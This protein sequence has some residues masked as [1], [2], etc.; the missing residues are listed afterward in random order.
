MHVAHLTD[1]LVEPRGNTLPRG[2]WKYK[3][4]ADCAALCPGFDWTYSDDNGQLLN[5]TEVMKAAASSRCSHYR[6]IEAEERNTDKTTRSFQETLRS[7]S[8]RVDNWPRR[9][10]EFVKE[11]INLWSHYL[12]RHDYIAE[13]FI[14]L[15]WRLPVFA[16]YVRQARQAGARHLCE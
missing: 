2:S 8:V 4:T 15:P 16:A 7:Q 10:I 6:A 3:A 1:S 11:N 9:D 12:T 14:N 5:T 13:S